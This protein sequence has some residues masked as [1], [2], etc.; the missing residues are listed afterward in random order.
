MIRSE[1]S[2]Q[3]EV[4]QFCKEEG[5]LVCGIAHATFTT[6]FSA[7]AKNKKGGLVKGFPD[8]V[9]SIPTERRKNNQGKCLFIEMKKEKGGRVS[10]EQE[11]WI[12]A[13]D[14]CEGVSAS[15]CRG[16]KEAIKFISHFIEKDSEINYDLLNF[17]K[18]GSN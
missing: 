17:L 5:L 10:K 12:N 14:N 18:N 2:E 6:S 3:S 8:L 9:I 4:I 1:L 11:E 7:I 16:A 15:V 13:L